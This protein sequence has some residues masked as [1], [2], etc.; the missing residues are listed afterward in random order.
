MKNIVMFLIICN[1]HLSASVLGQKVTL[2]LKNATLNECLQSIEKQSELGFLYMGEDLF[3]IDGISIH[4]DDVDVKEVLEQ[5]L[6]ERGYE[7]SIESNIIL[8]QKKQIS[9]INQEV[10]QNQEYI[11]V[12]GKVTDT[13]GLPIPGVNVV[14]MDVGIG[15]ITNM[16]G[17]YSINLPNSEGLELRY[18][19]IGMKTVTLLV[20]NQTIINVVMETEVSDLDEV[21]ITGFF[22]RK[23]DTYTG[24]TSTV[25]GEELLQYGT[26]NVLESLNQLDPSF[27]ILEN[28]QFGSDPNKLPEIS[29]RGASSF[30]SALDDSELNL[31]KTDPNMPTF[32]LDGFVVSLQDVIDLDMNRVESIT[33]LKDAVAAVVYGSYAANGVFVI[34]TK[35]PEVGKMR[36]S[37]SGNYKVNVPDLS[38]YDMLNGEELL[39]YQENLGLYSQ[40]WDDRHQFDNYMQIK[41]WLYE[42]VDT[43]WK[44]QAVQNAFTQQHSLNLSGGDQSVR[45]GLGANYSDDKGVMKGSYRKN[46][47]INMNLNYYVSEK[48]DFTNLL[49][50]NSNKANNSQYGSFSDYLS[51][52]NYF[53]LY[54][55]NGQ[56]YEQWGSNGRWGNLLRTNPLKEAEVGNLN[57]SEY[58][59][60]VN[61]LALNWKITQSLKL[62]SRLGYSINKSKM[63]DFL[64][65]KS[66]SYI[67]S[68]LP[69]DDRGEYMI[70]NTKSENISFNLML[71]YTYRHENH[72]VTSTV[73]GTISEAKS[74][75]DGMVAQGFSNDRYF[76]SFAKGYEIGG[77]PQGTEATVRTVGFLGSVNYSFR[78]VILLDGAFRMDGSSTFG[79][80]EKF[81]PFFSVGTGFNLSSTD[82]VKNITWLNTL[83]ITGSYG[84]TGS[85][86]FAPYQARDMFS[87]YADARYLGRIGVS[88]KALGNESL[89]W[90]TTK[91]KEVNLQLSLFDDL[92]DITA[93]IYDR[94][95]V[96]MIA[97]V[98]LPSSSGFKDMTSNLGEMSNRGID[99][100]FRSIIYKNSNSNLIFTFSGGHVKNEI[101]SIS[102]GLKSYNERLEEAAGEN[103]GKEYNFTSRFIEGRSVDDLYAVR[104]LGIDPQ[105]GQELFLDKDGN[106]TWEWRSEDMVVV[107]NRAP[108]LEGSIGLNYTYKRFSASVSSMYRLGGVA[109]N[110]TLLDKVENSDKWMNVDRRALELTWQQPGD[111][112][113]FKANADGS[114][115]QA[116]SRFVQDN[117]QFQ[118]MTLNLQYRI[119]KEWC[120]KLLMKSMS[121]GVAM[122]DLLY[123]STIERERGTTYPF[124]RSFS[125]RLNANF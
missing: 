102:D 54:D 92:F 4:V 16:D 57:R 74:I 83:R 103:T 121:V 51:L 53:P 18:S 31:L 76:P 24:V 77:I 80:E 3:D 32:V 99:F 33:I 66:I 113:P 81:A 108:K 106:P 44:S 56:I 70:N 8:I 64:S 59:N 109:Y 61:N 100:N 30:E 118:L 47:S 116:S 39:R 84:E 37:Y 73:G 41:Q 107:G 28:N 97:P 62:T 98:T 46:F 9:Q 34:K 69:V 101:M 27:R 67:D 65:P 78:N 117:N 52:P 22:E 21:V 12:E 71:N 19:S 11:L 14:C 86:S 96:D 15:G 13:D 26:D 68:Q 79:T 55:T 94:R 42:G 87:Y 40:D 43:D 6:E 10:S 119:S 120:S 89:V 45:Y 82:F 48:F 2:K 17:N 90:Q 5:L 85:I 63:E 111:I 112:V 23:K 115:T 1:V 49:S 105:T 114:T 29:F 60:M 72:V 38:S 104:S 50:F 124:A 75:S 93:S 25:K 95:T 35:D 91:S 123:V 88:L 125:L 20:N 36:V 58:T 7:Y 110:Q 122:D